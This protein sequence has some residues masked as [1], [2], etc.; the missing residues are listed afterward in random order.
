MSADLEP[1]VDVDGRPRIEFEF[2]CSDHRRNLPARGHEPSCAV[3]NAASV[4]TVP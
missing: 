2:R 4:P 1:Q 3:G